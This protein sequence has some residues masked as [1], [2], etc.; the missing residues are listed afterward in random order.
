MEIPSHVTLN[1][2][3]ENQILFSNNLEDVLLSDDGSKNN[4][5]VHK[6]P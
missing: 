2:N 1:G 3:E 5:P 4:N 6:E